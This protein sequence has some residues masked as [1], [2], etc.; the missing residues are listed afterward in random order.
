MDFSAWLALVSIC[1]LGAL[2]PGPSLALVIKNTLTGGR[3][4]GVAA[5]V[6]HGVG[7]G[8]Y[9]L[10]TA[11]G[12]AVLIQQT[13]WLFELIRYAGAGFLAWLGIN[14]LRSRGSDLPQVSDYK[15]LGLGQSAWQGFMLAFLNPKL[16]IFF[17]ALFSQF[18]RPE[19]GWQEK[20]IMMFTVGGIDAI[21]YAL[22]ALVLSHG[23]MLDK[24]RAKSQM[25]DR[26]SGVVLMG[27]AVRAVTL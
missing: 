18:V 9:A 19:A 25:I 26:I 8:F 13:P 23:S 2:S 11:L 14:A 1:I 21:W 6:A 10:I 16:A 4:P 15:A 20:L 5:G 22:V 7:V 12:L 3:G 27:L 17:L 24:L